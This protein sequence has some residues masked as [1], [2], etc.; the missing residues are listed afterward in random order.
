MAAYHHPGWD[1]MPRNAKAKVMAYVDDKMNTYA[2]EHELEDIVRWA[3]DG[4]GEHL[5]DVFEQGFNTGFA[6]AEDADV[7]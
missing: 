1:D 4:L 6:E 3:I 5:D 2:D 7:A